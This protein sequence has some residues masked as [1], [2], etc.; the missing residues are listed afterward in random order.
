MELVH[1]FQ[2]PLPAGEAWALLTDLG[3]VAVCMPGARLDTAEGDRYLGRVKVKLGAITAEFRGAARFAELDPT[4]RRFV[5]A[6]EGRD[7][8][9]Q[10]TASATVAVA[11]T[12][13][14][15]DCTDV[16]ITTTLS[17]AG[18]IAQFGRG[19]MQ[20]VSSRLLRQFVSALETQVASQPGQAPVE[21]AS[22]ADSAPAAPA[23][24]MPPPSAGQPAP[25]PPEDSAPDA[26]DLL[27]SVGPVLLRRAAPILVTVLVLALVLR[28]GRSRGAE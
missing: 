4:A 25:V 21:A 7:V 27:A 15:R 3:R 5:I 28:R 10:S 11:L 1:D 22:A 9:G 17:T 26:V 16:K 23:G 18:K 20:D 8:R 13:Q 6:A 12:E 19:V 2:L 24:A 14:A